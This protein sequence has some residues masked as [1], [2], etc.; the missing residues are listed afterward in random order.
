MA[1]LGE[2]AVAG[3]TAIL[4][5]EQTDSGLQEEAANALRHINTNTARA[6]LSDGN[7]IN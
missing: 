5:N 3:V 4:N 6:A 7:T 2:A 1:K